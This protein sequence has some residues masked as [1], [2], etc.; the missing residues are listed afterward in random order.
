MR[1]RNYLS[2]D[3]QIQWQILQFHPPFI[4]TKQFFVYH[5]DYDKKE[6]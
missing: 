3:K 6:N 4:D 2:F 5:S 1:R